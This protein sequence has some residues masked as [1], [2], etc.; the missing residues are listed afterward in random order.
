[1]DELNTQTHTH[2][3]KHT[4]V[5]LFIRWLTVGYAR[6]LYTGGVTVFIKYCTVMFFTTDTRYFFL[7]PDLFY[8]YERGGGGYSGGG[9][10]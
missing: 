8:L 5:R 4:F 10:R 1:M 6:F 7:Y 2:T 3:Q 9:S